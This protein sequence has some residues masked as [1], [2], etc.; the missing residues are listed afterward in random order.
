MKLLIPL[1]AFVLLASTAN[2]QQTKAT[3]ERARQIT[4]LQDDSIKVRGILHDLIADN[5]PT[6]S[7]DDFEMD[8]TTIE[9]FYGA[10]DCEEEDDAVWDV[11]TGKAFRVEIEWDS[12]VTAADLGIELSKL[13]KEQVYTGNED[14]FIYHDKNKGFAVEVDEGLVSKVI[15]FPAKSSNAKVCDSKFAKEFVS[16]KS[17]FGSKQ[18]KDRTGI[19][20]VAGP[21]NVTALGLSTDELFNLAQKKVNVTV[22]AVDPENDPLVYVYVVSAGKIVGSGAKV[23]WDLSGVGPGMYTITAGVDDGCGLCGTTKTQVI[24]IK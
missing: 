21:A 15:L 5:D 7:S 9:V 8:G 24:T 16:Y 20:C 10:N 4:L 13:E 3:I 17:W 11:P 2:A 18:L 23:I 19:I 12:D 14:R 6:D 22:T 1:F